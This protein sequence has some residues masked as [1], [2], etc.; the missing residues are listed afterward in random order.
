MPVILP[1]EQIK[2]WMACDDGD[3]GWAGGFRY[4]PVRPFGIK[5]DGPELIEE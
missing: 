1:V 2:P 3:Y 5:D 4:H